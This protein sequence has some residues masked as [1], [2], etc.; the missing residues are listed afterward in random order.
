MSRIG[1][2]SVPFILYPYHHVFMVQT[3]LSLM[4]IANDGHTLDYI[5]IVNAFRA[6]EEDFSWLKSSLDLVVVNDKNNLARAWNKG[7]KLAFERGADYA[8][9]INLDLVFH[10][11]F[12]VNILDFA[13]KTPEA[14]LW[15]GR[16]W[17][18]QA[19]L[20]SEPLEQGSDDTA[21]MS[22]FM[23][24]KRLF[25]KVGEFDEIFEPAYH[26]DK[27]MLYRIKIAGQKTKRSL[28]ARYFHIDRTTLKGATLNN[29]EAFLATTRVQMDISME[30]YGEKWGGLPGSEKFT[31][32]YNKP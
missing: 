32:P 27:D 9:V 24:D 4:Q 30:R 23:I 19:T 17:S 22:C 3:Y 10:S 7:I 25:E 31:K 28:A 5:A 16:P 14:I 12:L 20:E 6:S 29:D 13:R 11:Q 2:V 18:D 15:S 21:D 26:E 8:L 1:V